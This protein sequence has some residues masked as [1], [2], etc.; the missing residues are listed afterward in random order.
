MKI[1]G[2]FGVVVVASIA[3]LQPAE[4]RS[5]GSSHSFSSAPHF[6][7][8]AGHFSSRSSNSY[9][10]APRYYSPA[11]R[12]SSQAAF[13]NRNY[14]RSSSRFSSRAVSRNRVASDS[15]QFTANRTTALNPTVDSRFD[16][17]RT[18]NRTT[19]L[20]PQ[21]FN[22]NQQ[23]VV[24]EQT[25]NWNRHRDHNWRG[26]R[27]RW[28]NNSWVIIGPW[29]YPWAYGY[30]PYGAYSYYDGYY[31]DGYAANE[32]SQSEYDNGD[33]DSSV[34]RVQAALAKEGYYR[35]A[36]DGSFGPATQNALRRYQRNHGLGV[37]GEIDRPVIQALGLG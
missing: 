15:R 13:R 5:R 20:R 8:S 19:A 24:A 10:T 25:R 4:G 27:C 30:Y 17:R 34:R 9:R 14:T 29:F 36:I 12:S 31:D 3:L 35:G 16:S 37:T 28:H 18:A 22:N 2:T 23:R 21:N 33:L 7:R 6:S 1:I 32:Y 26:H 11:M